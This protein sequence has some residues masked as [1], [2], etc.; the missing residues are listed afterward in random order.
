MNTI[1]QEID[2]KDVYCL[3]MRKSEL[4]DLIKCVGWFAT[5]EADLRL[6]PKWQLLL[7]NLYECK[8]QEWQR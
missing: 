4:N 2:P 6:L 3:I 8:R 5:T 7:E 1:I